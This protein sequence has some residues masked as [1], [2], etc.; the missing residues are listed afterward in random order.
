VGEGD[1]EL[2]GGEVDYRD[3]VAGGAV[4]A[5]AV[6]GGLDVGW[7]PSKRPLEMRECHQLTISSQYSS[8]IGGKRMIGSSGSGGRRG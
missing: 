5:G 3:V 1:V 6:F 7:R 8:T 2:A 4:A